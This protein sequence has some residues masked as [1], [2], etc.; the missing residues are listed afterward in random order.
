MVAFLESGREPVT[1]AAP[2]IE[3]QPVPVE[4]PTPPPAP[5]RLEMASKLRALLAR[6][7]G[8]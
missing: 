4:L 2:V 1:R 7:R 3:A 8:Q 5:A 6:M